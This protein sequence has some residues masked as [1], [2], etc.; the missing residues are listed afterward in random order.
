MPYV[1]ETA[2][3]R[4]RHLVPDD[5]DFL[6]AMLGDAEV[7]RY[8]PAV[9]DR[10]GARAWLDRQLQRYATDG[11]APW[12]VEER[13]SGLPVGQV[14]PLRQLLPGDTIPSVEVGYLLQRSAWGMGYA[15]EAARATRDWVFARLG[16]PR[17]V[18]LIRPE[19][20]RSRRVAMRNGFRVIGEVMHAGLLHD[21]W[22]MDR[23]VWLAARDKAS[24]I[25]ARTN[26]SH[27]GDIPMSIAQSILPEFEH[28][29]STTRKLI[30][31]TPI[32]QMAWKPHEKSM[33]LGQLVAHLATLP[34]WGVV[35]MAQTELDLNPPG[36]PG[37]KTPEFD[38]VDGLLAE[39]DKNVAGSRAAIAAGADPDFMVGWTL[40]N[41]GH[42]IFTLPRIAV[43]RT[44]VMNHVIHH[45]GQYSVYLR[46]NNVPLPSMYGPTADEQ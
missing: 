3:L 41:G 5:L 44:F 34:G 7:M 6:A 22:G 19:N 10:D 26:P 28:E 40:K 32:A 29:M 46:L 18:S 45:R 35:T 21:V 8:Y 33:S 36:G 42:S 16:T 1:L 24:D 30:E 2:R 37:Y 38:S 27:Y 23:G 39:F 17:V 4:L 20:G 43:L 14:G 31:R 13:D 9:L 15:S 12:L 25:P 11:F